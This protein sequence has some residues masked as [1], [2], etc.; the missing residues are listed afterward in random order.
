M[1]H[2]RI[3]SRQ[4]MIKEMEYYFTIGDFITENEIRGLY[5][6]HYG[7]GKRLRD[8]TSIRNAVIEEEHWE[9]NL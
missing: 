4:K 6:F 7:D 1:K 5:L 9:R 3:Q 2:H 8:Y